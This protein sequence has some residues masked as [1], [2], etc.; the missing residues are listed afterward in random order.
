MELAKT[1]KERNYE[2][3][4]ILLDNEET[5]ICG[6]CYWVRGPKKWNLNML[7]QAVN[8]GFLKLILVADYFKRRKYWCER[9]NCW[10]HLLDPG[11]SLWR[12]RID[13]YGEGKDT[14]L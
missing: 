14:T 7:Y 11:C 12:R 13:A 9:E 2:S 5:V 6:N 10:T 3:D 1:N 4:E 8:E